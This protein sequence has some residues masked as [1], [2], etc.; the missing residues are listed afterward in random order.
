[1]TRRDNRFG[2]IILGAYRPRYVTWMCWGATLGNR[3]RFVA[4]PASGSRHNRGAAVDLTRYHLE[5]GRPAAMGSGY[6]EFT[7]Q[8]YPDCQGVT[9]E[10]REN[11]DRL[12]RAMEE[13]GLTI[14]PYEW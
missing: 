3:R 2:L 9:A 5:S 1:M 14:Y 13:Q 7:E 6:D 4:D 8:S 11:K 12:W 10:E